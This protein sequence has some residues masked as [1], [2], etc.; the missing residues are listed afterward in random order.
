MGALANDDTSGN[1]TTP[2]GGSP[3]G[4]TNSSDSENDATNDNSA[5]SLTGRGTVVLAALGLVAGLVL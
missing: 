3:S 1:I 2:G 5:S 4:N